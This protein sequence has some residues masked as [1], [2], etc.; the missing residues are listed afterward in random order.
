MSTD[1]S[2]NG[3]FTLQFVAIH[4]IKEERNIE[5]VGNKHGRILSES[6]LG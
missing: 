4:Q 2:E 1:N 6:H 3:E 5:S